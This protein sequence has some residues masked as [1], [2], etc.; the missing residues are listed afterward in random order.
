MGQKGFSVAAHSDMQMISTHNDSVSLK[1]LAISTAK[2][3][4]AHTDF[5]FISKHIKI[6]TSDKDPSTYIKAFKDKHIVSFIS[7]IIKELY[8]CLIQVC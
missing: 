4:F 1:L 8:H 6:N 7:D 5:F 2:T 3:N